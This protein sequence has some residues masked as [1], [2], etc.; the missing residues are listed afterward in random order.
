MGSDKKIIIKNE[1]TAVVS[2]A[3]TKQMVETT[4][5]YAGNNLNPN[6]L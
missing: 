3:D 1:Q 5:A 6:L 2:F 4:T